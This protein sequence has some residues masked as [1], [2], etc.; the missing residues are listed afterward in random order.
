MF[1]QRGGAGFQME[2]L[3]LQ[4][5]GGEAGLQQVAERVDAGLG[6]AAARS[7]PDGCSECLL[8]AGGF[9]FAIYSVQLNV[10]RGGVEGDLLECIFQAE[11]RGLQAG[12]RCLDVLALRKS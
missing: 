2:P 12:A 4:L 5:G 10:S 3:E 1:G 7:L 11:V 8:L 9:Q 6:R